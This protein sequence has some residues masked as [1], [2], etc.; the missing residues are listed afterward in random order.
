MTAKFQDYY[1]TLGV[2]RTASAAEI[3]KAH[4][5]LSRQHHPDLN[6]GNKEAETKFKA[7]Q[8]AYD[9]LSDDKKRP[10]YDQLGEHWKAGAEFQP[11]PGWDQAGGGQVREAGAE[12]WQAAFGGAGSGEEFSDFF[13]TLFGAR[14]RPF[15]SGATFRMQGRDLEAELPLTLEEAHR[16][17]TRV[18]SMQGW[19]RCREC[20]GTGSVTNQRCGRC[21]GRGVEPATNTL[22]VSVPPG[23]R[24]GNVL[25]LNGQGEPGDRGGPAGDLLVHIR[26]L[27]H[28]R[29]TREGADNL[30][31]ELSVA[32]WEAVLGA[33][34]SLPTLDGEV[35]MTVPGGSQ[36]GQRLRLR[37]QG[38]SR[39]DGSRGDLYARL[40]VVV[41]T[42][43]SDA[44]RELFQQ[45]AATSAFRPR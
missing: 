33:K 34:V 16:G 22:Q 43:V 4:R 21:A 14:A 24:D 23:V 37:G 31:T 12:D 42:Q 38:L 1:E 32:A 3:K 9:V 19:E 39:R 7:V 13:Q 28:A 35:D 20:D 18:V 40:K 6:P 25:R 45:L 10:R 15:R 26:L 2:A 36:T 41:P 44:E 30:L 5:K 17:S 11:P 27:P 8:E 29:F